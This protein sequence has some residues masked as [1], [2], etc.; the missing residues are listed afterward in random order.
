MRLI[1]KSHAPY[2]LQQRHENPPQSWR[3][4]TTAWN[5]FNGKSDVRNHLLE[6]QYGLCA[7]S[8]IRPDEY[9]LG[10]H[11]EHIRPKSAYPQHTFDYHNLVVCALS[12]QDMGR[13]QQS[14][15]FGG[16]AKGSDYDAARFISPLDELCTDA[17]VYL[18]DGRI[19]VN[20][21]QN[22]E[23]QSKADYT[24]KLLN[25]NSPYLVNARK[26]WLEELDAA[27]DE[28]LEHAEASAHL[29]DLELGLTNH[30]LRSFHSASCQRF[31]RLGKQVIKEHYPELA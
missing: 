23:Q 6:E 29:A 27:I 26:R 10:S 13:M 3:S 16:H 5:S 14:D 20:G 24:I 17:F 31:G 25:L 9:E 19:E 12:D 1:K 4:A 2:R 8:E 30:T 21:R 15:L 18:S 22:K 7:Y 11:I 28:L